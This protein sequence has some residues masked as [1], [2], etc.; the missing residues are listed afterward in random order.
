MCVVYSVGAWRWQICG[1]HSKWGAEWVRLSQMNRLID[2]ESER[3]RGGSRDGREKRGEIRDERALHILLYQSKQPACQPRLSLSVSLFPS[4]SLSILLSL[5]D[6]WQNVERG[7]KE[8]RCREMEGKQILGQHGCV[9]FWRWFLC[10]FVC[11]DVCTI[12]AFST[13][14]DQKYVDA[15]ALQPCGIPKPG[16]WVGFILLWRFWNLAGNDLLPLVTRALVRPWHCCWLIRSVSQIVPK[17]WM[18]F[19]SAHSAGQTPKAE[20]HV[21]YGLHSVQGCPLLTPQDTTSHMLK[22]VMTWQD[23]TTWRNLA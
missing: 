23:Y 1:N 18:W 6:R 14:H 7:I 12:W 9:N 5:P 20:N 15:G 13:L 17:H 11:M 16:A 19:R 22:I 21:F 10:S 4:L 2:R 3:R 8:K